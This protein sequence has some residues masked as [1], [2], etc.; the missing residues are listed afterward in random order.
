MKVFPFVSSRT[1]YEDF[2]SEHLV[3]PDDLEWEKMRPFLS[4]STYDLTMLGDLRYAVFAIG[5][6][7]VF[8]VGCLSRILADKAN[9][10]VKDDLLKDIKRRSLACFIG[11]AVKISD[12]GKGSSEVPDMTSD[13]FLKTCCEM[14]FK[15]LEKQWESKTPVTE[16]IDKNG[17]SSLDG[18][19]CLIE[20]K[21]TGDIPE[22]P[23]KKEFCGISVTSEKFDRKWFS[24][25][26]NEIIN[27]G[28][29]DCSFVS[30][31]E[32][33]DH[34]NRLVPCFK[35]AC[36]S[37]G[38]SN[39]LLNIDKRHE[40][41]ET[42]NRISSLEKS[43]DEF[44]LEAKNLIDKIEGTISGIYTAKK[45]FDANLQNLDLENAESSLCTLGKLV[46][47]SSD[48]YNVDKY[49]K[50][51]EIKL[52]CDELKKIEL[53]HPENKKALDEA[54]KP[55]EEKLKEIRNEGEK[56]DEVIKSVDINE[57][58][59]KFDEHKNALDN[60]NKYQQEF[61][62]TQDKTHTPEDFDEYIGTLKSLKGD[63]DKLTLDNAEFKKL[64]DELSGK[65]A[66]EIETTQKQKEDFEKINEIKEELEKISI[67]STDAIALLN[68]L[69]RRANPDNF[70][71]DF[72][73]MARELYTEIQKKIREAKCSREETQKQTSQPTNG[74][75]EE[76]CNIALKAYK[77]FE[78][79]RESISGEQFYD[80]LLEYLSDRDDLFPDRRC[81]YVFYTT[82]DTSKELL[83]YLKALQSQNKI[84]LETNK[85]VNFK[86]TLCN[87]NRNSLKPIK[88]MITIKKG[89]KN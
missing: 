45:S 88:C 26:L 1:K 42:N 17:I 68:E 50:L 9:F 8:G 30:H 57:L 4:G 3:R 52:K 48:K 61:N 23:T 31:V 32:F 40:Q 75:K 21:T 6:Y 73:K 18:K 49:D 34:W 86:D 38:F 76:S 79:F 33:E 27:K 41:K 58:E 51:K 54:L 43:W 12:K 59:N 55:F 19:Q 71:Q 2:L 72:K 53:K 63:V 56:L 11:F 44:V 64:K 10:K 47:T 14:Y 80:D 67:D 60:L 35:N 7:C 25:Y 20:L 78:E 15:H 87:A 36:V 22:K 5:D 66:K 77:R 85:D 29:K 39:N 70:C 69:L 89:R 37:Q 82:K 62:E 81:P 16:K 74:L 46:N 84:D 13:D 28:N 83:N 24:Y 65:I